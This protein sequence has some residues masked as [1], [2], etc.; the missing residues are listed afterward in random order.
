MAS[1]WI[2]VAAFNE[3]NSLGTVVKNLR[4]RG[5]DNIVVVDD[6]SKDDTAAI[7]KAA[8]AHVVQHCINRGQGAALQT[9]IDFAL[10]NGAEYIVT[11][12]ADGQHRVEDISK[13]LEPLQDGAYDI[14]LGSRFLD[15]GSN[16]PFIRK[17][18]L[19]GGAFLMWLFYGV[20]LTDSHNGFRVFSRRAAEKVR[21]ECDRME[22]ASEIVD[23]IGKSHL[24]FKEVPVT[25]RYTEY[26][27]A[28]GQ[29]T[30]NAFRILYKMIVNK[31]FR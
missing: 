15:D 8:G 27:M 10:M 3:Q 26:S 1:V 20:K 29:S 25:I 5:Y 9:G 23:K 24:K 14:S 13:M 28:R 31:F 11:F 2:V 4:E 16:V 18:F 12:D 21:I 6:G 17:V 30:W 19:K 7:A 22:H